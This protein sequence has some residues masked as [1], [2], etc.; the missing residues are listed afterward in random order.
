[1]MRHIVYNGSDSPEFEDPSLD[2]SEEPI[3]F[4]DDDMMWDRSNPDPAYWGEE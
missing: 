2:E 4:V 3:F 1:M